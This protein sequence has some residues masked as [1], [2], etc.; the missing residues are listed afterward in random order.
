MSALSG[1]VVIG[2]EKRRD[3]VTLNIKGTSKKQPRTEEELASE[4]GALYDSDFQPF[5]NLRRPDGQKEGK[6]IKSDLV[7]TSPI[8]N[9]QKN[10]TEKD[11]QIKS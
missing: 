2:E 1:R 9:P 3:A 7:K 4:D 11:N 5:T 8:K 10:P 6:K